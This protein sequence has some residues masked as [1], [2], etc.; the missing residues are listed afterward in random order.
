MM[1]ISQT[2][3]GGNGELAKLGEPIS[4]NAMHRFLEQIEVDVHSRPSPIEFE[5]ACQS[6]VGIDRHCCGVL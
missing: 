6:R 1:R 2:L 5:M 3:S 4:S